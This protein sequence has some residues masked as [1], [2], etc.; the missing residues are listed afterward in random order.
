VR[1]AKASICVRF[2]LAAD[3]RVAALLLGEFVDGWGP[4]CSECVLVGVMSK[5]IHRTGLSL[6]SCGRVWRLWGNFGGSTWRVQ[7]L[8]K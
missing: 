3:A 7:Q 2:M 4:L 1:A 8:P 5:L 6:V